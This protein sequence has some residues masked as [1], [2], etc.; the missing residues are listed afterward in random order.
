MWRHAA[1]L[2]AA[3]A[4]LAPI[5]QH[6]SQLRAEPRWVDGPT[7]IGEA[8]AMSRHIGG[9]VCVLYFNPMGE[10]G[11]AAL[12]TVEFAGS[13]LPQCEFLLRLRT[14]IKSAGAPST[15][16]RRI[17][18]CPASRSLMAASPKVLWRPAT[19]LRH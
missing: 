14:E 6:K 8:G 17:K 4:F 10:G 15:P 1:L 5:P 12:S 3:A 18:L 13:A 9:A 19:L 2:G 7:D 16:Y 11:A